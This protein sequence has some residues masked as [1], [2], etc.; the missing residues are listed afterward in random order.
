VGKRATSVL[1]AGIFVLGAC[2]GGSKSAG[3]TIASTKPNR[4][5]SVPH[6]T[7]SVPRPTTTT[8][9]PEYSFDDS[10]PPPKL[11]N[12]GTDYVAILESLNRYGNWLAAHHPDPALVST[13]VA[14]GTKQHELFSLDLTRLRDNHVRLIEKVGNRPTGF[15]IL[16]RT[17]NAFSARVVQDV[18][19]HQS[20]DSRGKVTSS[21]LFTKPTTYLILVVLER[22]RWYF[23]A[24]DEED[25]ANVRL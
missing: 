18:R 3:P 24:L 14:I 6:A 2:T 19:V 16:S 15:T 22:G 10:V 4:V 12:T 1:V 8:S 13:I 23:A 5:T 11:M 20:V 21:V 9:T 17:A 25:P 7:T